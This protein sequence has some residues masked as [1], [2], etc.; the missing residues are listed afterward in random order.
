MYPDNQAMPS[1]P[2]SKAALWAGRATSGLCVLF[3]VL[4]GAVKLF[5][6]APVL[7]AC[8]QLGIPESTIPGIGL[9]LLAST[10]A[11][12]IPAT[13]VLGAILLTGYLGGAIATHVRVGGPAFPVAFAAALGVLVWLGIYLREPRLR[14][15]VPLRRIGTRS[16]DR[17]QDDGESVAIES[18][19]PVGT[20]S[21]E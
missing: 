17:A 8:A 1:P 13:S 20:R 16:T 6:P 11:Y 9:V 10:A 18:A 12:A 19:W 2:P 5:K 15:L 7:K 3:L 21:G 14:A 4:D